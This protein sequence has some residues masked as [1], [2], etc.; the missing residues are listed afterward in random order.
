MET[1]TIL[2]LT[3][4]HQPLRLDIDLEGNTV[5]DSRSS[6]TMFR[7]FELMLEGRD[8]RDA[9]YLC[10]RICGI[11]STAHGVAATS[12]IEDA[13]G[14]EVTP[15]AALMRNLIYGADIL[16]NHLRHFYVLA[17]PDYIDTPNFPPFVPKSN[18]DK[19]LSKAENDKL[20]ESYWLGVDMSRLAHQLLAIYGGKAPHQHGI[21]VGGTSMVPDADRNNRFRGLLSSLLR[22]INE[23]MLPNTELIATRYNDYFKIGK[24]P[25]TFLSYGMFPQQQGRSKLKYPAGVYL[26]GKYAELDP[27]LI[28]ED[29]TFTW[30]SGS[31]AQE[32]PADADS[33]PD[34]HKK[35]GYT[36]LKAPRYANQVMEMGP[37]ARMWISGDY[38][39]GT[40]TMDRLIAR[41]LDAKKIATWMLEWLDELA[42]GQATF[43]PFEI[44][45]S[46]SGIGLTEAMRGS[47][48]HWV[49][50]EAKKIAHYQIITPTAW[51]FSP[52]DKNG[53][54]G[55]V[56]TA[57]VGTKVKDRDNFSEIGRIVR[58]FDPCFSCSAHLLEPQG[59]I[60]E[61]RI[62]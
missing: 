46:G 49:K 10:E 6:G 57:I 16:Q 8:P 25:G 42:P 18:F 17:L 1:H 41:T 55:A 31:K 47:L 20:L 43:T 56:D 38:R 39:N 35:S 15:N 62:F 60:D 7:G 24:G 27:G 32:K 36:W 3:R 5:I 23:H 48:G 45:D 29:N 61:F 44:P 22:F 30:F 34:R 12:A 40:S 14:L 21:I 19:R 52:K 54:R 28:T 4:I 58:S 53:K 59:Q 26:N 50:I 9:T 33:L 13:I 2:P 37:L 51:L 11:C